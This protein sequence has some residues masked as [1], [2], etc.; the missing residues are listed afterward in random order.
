MT[1]TDVIVVMAVLGSFL[2]LILAR[3]KEK[4]PKRHEAIVGW[5]KKGKEKVKIPTKEQIEV[6]KLPYDSRIM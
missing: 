6:A 5:M 3:M 1:L 2:F 4:N